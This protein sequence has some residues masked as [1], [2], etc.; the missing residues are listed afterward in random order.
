MRPPGARRRFARHNR[1][2]IGESLVL[3]QEQTSGLEH[4]EWAL[5]GCQVGFLTSSMSEDITSVIG[6]KR[7]RDRT[8]FFRWVSTQLEGRITTESDRIQ[9][10]REKL[11]PR[12]ESLCRQSTRLQSSILMKSSAT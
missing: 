7:R 1:D 11:S 4:D 5:G 3:E 9:A 6:K 8:A 2:D 10:C 12:N